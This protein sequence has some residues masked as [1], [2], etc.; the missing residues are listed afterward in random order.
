MISLYETFNKN[1]KSK[2]ILSQ[3][4]SMI[5]IRGRRNINNPPGFGLMRQRT[6]F[7]GFE[8]KKDNDKITINILENNKKIGYIVLSDKIKNNILE[9]IKVKPSYQIIDFEIDM[10]LRTRGYGMALF[11][12]MFKKY[13]KILAITG[14]EHLVPKRIYQIMG[15]KLIHTDSAGNNYWYYEK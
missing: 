14:N 1:P 6:I 7:Y 4:N 5:M 10:N 15:F 11:Q 13:N 2:N 9:Q 8:E 12:E 3:E